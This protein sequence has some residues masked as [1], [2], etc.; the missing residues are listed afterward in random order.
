M[1]INKIEKRKITRSFDGKNPS[2]WKRSIDNP[3]ATDRE[4]RRHK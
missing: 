1:E 4:N 3:L 2:S